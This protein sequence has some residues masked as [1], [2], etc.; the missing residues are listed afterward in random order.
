MHF[1]SVFAV[2]ALASTATAATMK[3]EREC[4][5]EP[6]PQQLAAAQELAREE[7][8]AK[9][10]QG[11]ANQATTEAQAITTVPVY[12]HVVTTDDSHS[13]SSAYVSVSTPPPLP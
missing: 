1:K 8:A 10:A 5:M 6:T 2:A 4:L 9:I 3:H 7:A 13:S 12:A 11:F